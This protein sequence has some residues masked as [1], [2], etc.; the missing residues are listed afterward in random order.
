MYATMRKHILAAETRANIN[1]DKEDFHSQE[2]YRNEQAFLNKGVQFYSHAVIEEHRYKDPATLRQNLTNYSNRKWTP[3][4]RD[5]LLR[6][7]GKHYCVFR[8]QKGL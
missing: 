5:I 8:G 7:A 4:N 6:Y 1:K 3:K 2:P